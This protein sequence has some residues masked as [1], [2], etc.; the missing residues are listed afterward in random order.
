MSVVLFF[1]VKG[2]DSQELLAGY[3]KTVEVPYPSPSGI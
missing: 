3:D 2:V 1:K